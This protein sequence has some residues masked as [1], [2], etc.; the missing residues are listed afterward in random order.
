[1]SRASLPRVHVT[2]PAQVWES[3]PMSHLKWLELK[4]NPVSQ[5]SN[6]QT[7][8]TPILSNPSFAASFFAICFV[9]P[10]PRPYASLSTKTVAHHTGVVFLLWIWAPDVASPPSSCSWPSENFHS[11]VLLPFCR[12]WLN[13]AR[14]PPA[15]VISS[16]VTPLL[17]PAWFPVTSLWRSYWEGSE[18]E[19]AGSPWCW[20]TIS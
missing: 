15:G 19:T 1:M 11:T 12:Y 4:I 9:V 16:S 20:R 13:N 3:I 14:Y 5:L 18:I 2:Q 8:V 7:T 10:F 17:S 6:P